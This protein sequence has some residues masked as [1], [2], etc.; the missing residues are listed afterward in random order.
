ML[1]DSHWHVQETAVKT[2]NGFLAHV[3]SWALLSTPETSQ[4]AAAMLAHTDPG[5][6][7]SVLMAMSAFLQHDGLRA[8]I[9]NEE[10]FQ[11][12]ATMLTDPDTEVP[13]LLRCAS[14]PSGTDVAA[15]QM[16]QLATPESNAAAFR[17]YTPCGGSHAIG[18]MLGP[19]GVGHGAT[20]AILLPAVYT[21]NARHETSY[22]TVVPLVPAP[23]LLP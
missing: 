12:I 1:E 23:P 19:F 16:A 21:Y 7:Y 11:D 10:T 22:N 8:M 15:R 4:E 6:R 9:A 14:D 3:D 18:H 5:V 2:L 20:S 17:V 13:A